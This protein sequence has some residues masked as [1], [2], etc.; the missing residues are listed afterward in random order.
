MPNPNNVK[1]SDLSQVGD[2]GGR[3][4]QVGRPL[5]VPSG[6]AARAQKAL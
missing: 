2:K 5:N 6:A 3:V 1:R 4:Q